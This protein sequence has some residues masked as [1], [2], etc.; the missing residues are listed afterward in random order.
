VDTDEMNA[1]L[2]RKGLSAQLHERYVLFC[3]LAFNTLVSDAIN[4]EGASCACLDTEKKRK[5]AM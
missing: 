2:L 3:D 1:E 4:Q 5:R